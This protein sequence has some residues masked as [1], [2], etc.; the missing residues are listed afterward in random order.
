VRSR[1]TSISQTR[2]LLAAGLALGLVGAACGSNASFRPVGAANASCGGSG[3]GGDAVSPAAGV[4]GGTRWLFRC[5]KPPVAFRKSSIELANLV[6]D[7]Q[8]LGTA[9]LKS[10]ADAAAVVLVEDDPAVPWGTHLHGAE[11]AIFRAFAG[12]KSSG[13]WLILVTDV[14]V[15]ASK[16][17][18]PPTAYRWSRADVAAFV[19]CGMPPATT[20]P[21][22]QRFWQSADQIVLAPAGGQPR[23]K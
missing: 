1:R 19:T 14:L 22:H 20:S 8:G 21:C 13:A 9:G 3:T 16:D 18:V 5:D 10:T 23:G 4:K 2:L 17:P 11:L 15:H 12:D 7:I 6:G